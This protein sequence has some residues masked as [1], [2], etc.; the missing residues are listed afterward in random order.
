MTPENLIF[1]TKHILTPDRPQIFYEGFL[2][3]KNEN[4]HAFSE[5]NF[6]PEQA[7]HN[8]L[9]INTLSTFLAHTRGYVEYIL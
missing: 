5:F 1:S 7:N 9:Y 6:Y 8:T 2:R 3:D 4:L